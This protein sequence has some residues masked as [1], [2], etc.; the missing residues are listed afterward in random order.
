MGLQDK[1]ILIT[2]AT[3]DVGPVVARAC[4]ETGARLVLTARK[5]ESLQKLAGD[6]GLA[7]ERALLV[8]AD[9]TQDADVR[10][11]IE[12]L[13]A[14]WGGADVLLNLVGGWGGGKRLADVSDADWDAMQDLNLRSALHINRAVLPYM[15]SRGWGRIVNM[16]SRAAAEPGARQAAYNVAKAGV[17]SL[18][19]SIA[20]DYRRQ[21]IAANVILPSMIDTPANRA[22]NPE[23]D[24][25]RWVKPTALAGLMLYLCS[26]EGGNLNGASL[27]VYGLL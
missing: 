10:A 15:L 6:L 2:G 4:A 21:G 9:L 14:R 1:V 16:A 3:G 5:L 17:V 22:S 11:L 24:Y 23:A 27:P 13:S 7:E 8:A 25:A 26:D 12:A 18:T 20:A 19:A